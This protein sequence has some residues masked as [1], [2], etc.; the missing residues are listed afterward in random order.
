MKTW[1]DEWVKS[2]AI[3]SYGKSKKGDGYEQS[4]ETREVYE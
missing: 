1:N 2:M 3:W 4:K